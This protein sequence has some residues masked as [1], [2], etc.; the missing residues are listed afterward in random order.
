MKQA[1]V[2]KTRKASLLCPKIHQCPSIIHFR[3]DLQ[4][5]KDRFH[6]KTVLQRH[7]AFHPQM[8]VSQAVMVTIKAIT[9]F[10]FV[11]EGIWSHK[12]TEGHRLASYRT[13]KS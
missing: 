9:I 11:K 13:V 1:K 4:Y 5:L 8:L 2:L 7:I 10:Q 3:N 6:R 12:T